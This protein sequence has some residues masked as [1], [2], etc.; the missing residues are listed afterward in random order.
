LGELVF[1]VSFDRVLEG[2]SRNSNSKE[3]KLMMDKI[4]RASLGDIFDR[5]TDSAS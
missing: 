4:R 5:I 1:G 3:F 2:V